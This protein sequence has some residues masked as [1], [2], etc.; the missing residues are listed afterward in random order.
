VHLTERLAQ[1]PGLCLGGVG[2][3]GGRGRRRR[4]ARLGAPR[5]A[6][7]CCRQQYPYE[8][9][10]RRGAAHGKPPSYGGSDGDPRSVITVNTGTAVSGPRGRKGCRPPGRTFLGGGARG[11]RGAGG[12]RPPGAG[13]AEGGGSAE[14]THTR[15]ESGRPRENRLATP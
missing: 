9:E 1:R 8:S 12:E 13:R 3:P 5:G 14:G 10:S 7:G 15:G 6:T 11:K 4:C 2:G